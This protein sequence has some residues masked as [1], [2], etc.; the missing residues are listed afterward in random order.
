MT[1]HGNSWERLIFV[2]PWPRSL[3]ASPVASTK[4]PRIITRMSF[5]SVA[6]WALRGL[7]AKAAATTWGTA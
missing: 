7:T 3:T 6:T 4:G 5:T 2:S 1:N